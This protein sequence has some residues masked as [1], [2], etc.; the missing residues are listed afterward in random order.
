MASDKVKEF[1]SDNF[2]S[3]VLESD[4]PVV[5]DFWAEWCGPCRM[6][7]PVIEELA[8][9]HEAGDI[10]QVD[11]LRV[12]DPQPRVRARHRRL[13]AP[14]R[15]T[16]RRCTAARRFRAE[17]RSVGHHAELRPAVRIV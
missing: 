5:V 2:Q 7:A 6:I 3:A 17:A 16:R 11:D 9:A 10:G 12:L 13:R 4:K 8:E 1:T 15:P 14:A